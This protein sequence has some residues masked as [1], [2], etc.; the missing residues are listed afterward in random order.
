M[1]V[2]KNAKFVHELTQGGITAGD[3]L[4]QNGKII[5]VA[6]NIEEENAEVIDLKEKYLIPGL[7]DLHVHLNL[8]GG[9]VLYDNFKDN[10][11][12][13]IESY[14]FSLDILK[15]GFTTIRD[16]GSNHAM[17]NGIRDAV[18]A[19][20]LMAPNIISSGRIIS[21]TENGNKYF[22]FMYAES[23]GI[24]EIT[25]NVR[26]EIQEGADFIKV[27]TSGAIMNPGGEPGSN[28]YSDEELKCIVDTARIKGRYVAAHAHGAESIRQCIRCGVRTIEHSTL[29]DDEGIEMALQNE[30]VYLVPTMTA[31]FGLM[32]NTDEGSQFMIEKTNRIREAYKKSLTK[33]YGAGLKVGFGTDQGITGQYHGDN[34]NEFTYRKDIIGMSDLD[35]L[36]QATIYSAKA[37]QIEDK[38]GLIKEGMTADFLVLNGNPAENIKVCVNGIDSVIKSGEIV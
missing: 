32:S 15:A 11:F 23:D 20:G 18:E 38:V 5:K 17:V 28:I 12:M 16:V 6:P 21:P 34:G 35:I 8:S 31:V 1:K 10:F 29:I 22:P 3:V 26:K 36:K 27:M 19:S 7:I 9:D 14:K 4:I 37:A 33:V 25:K 2:L 24:E 30:S 13:C